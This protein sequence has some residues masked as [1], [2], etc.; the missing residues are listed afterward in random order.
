MFI[1]Y[2][3]SGVDALLPGDLQICIAGRISALLSMSALKHHGYRQ[4][5][6]ASE[7]LT[8]SLKLASSRLITLEDHKA[9]CAGVDQGNLV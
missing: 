1:F 2:R 7:G 6:L 9:S 5:Y 4:K 3:Q 8:R